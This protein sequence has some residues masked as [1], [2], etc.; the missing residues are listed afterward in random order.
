MAPCCTQHPIALLHYSRE[1]S[2][3]SKTPGWRWAPMVGKKIVV[4]DV[5]SQS[6]RIISQK[7]SIIMLAVI[8]A[9][10]ILPGILIPRV[11]ALNP[12]RIVA[13]ILSF[14]LAVIV[15]GAYPS[16]VKTVLDG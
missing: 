11:S 5:I 12:L 7:P 9:V 10:F 8:P 6:V 2:Y 3:V 14:V 13:D 16:I 1:D 15:S 4:R